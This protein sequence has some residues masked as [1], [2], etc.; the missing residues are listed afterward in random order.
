MATDK[1]DEALTDAER[2]SREVAES[3]REKDW[4][5]P[6]FI[7]EMFLGNFRL[8]LIPPFPTRKERP[9]GGFG[10]HGAN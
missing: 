10:C 3:A 4:K 6:S 8:D 5:Q 2:K 7:R 1:H 9:E